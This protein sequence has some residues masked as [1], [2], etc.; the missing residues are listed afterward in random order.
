MALTLIK[1]KTNSQTSI[2]I[3]IDDKPILVNSNKLFIFLLHL[4][5]LATIC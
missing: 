1:F 2:T 5:I 4:I 3:N